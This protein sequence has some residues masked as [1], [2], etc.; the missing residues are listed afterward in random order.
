MYDRQSPTTRK[1]S[2]D[3]SDVR[4]MEEARDGNARAFAT[5]FERH[6][7]GLRSFIYRMVGNHHRAEELA[8]EAFL[9]IY[10]TRE[11][12][13]P[14]AAFS[15]YLYRVATNLSVNEMRRFEVGKLEPLE[16]SAGEDGGSAPS[17]TLADDG[18]TPEKRVALR[19][20]GER[21][22]DALRRLPPNQ[23]EALLLSR[24]EGMPHREVARRLGTS[25]FAIKNLVF[26]A[27]R[28][29]REAVEE[30]AYG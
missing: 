22:D 14:R 26:R 9:Q 29:L 15:T 24:V 18:P 6:A 2:D 7:G 21:V 23:R 1:R 4:L 17:S 12:Y 25:P 5:L 27:R 20:V 13:E 3:A 16:R 11:R 19:E 10:R 28:M 30:P 8:Q